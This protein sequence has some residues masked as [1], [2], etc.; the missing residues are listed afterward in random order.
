MR[1]ARLA[2]A[3]DPDASGQT[4]IIGADGAEDLSLF[5][6]ERTLIVESLAH[7]HHALAQRGFRVATA[8][9]GAFDTV[10]VTLPRARDAARA[11]IALGA[12]HL[13]PEGAMW[14]DGRKTDGVESIIKEIRSLAGIS[15]VHSKA[16]GKIARVSDPTAIT[17]DWLQDS[18]SPAPGFITRA[19]MF[20]ATEPD[21]GSQLLA[22]ALP[23]RMPT[24]VVDL[25][26]GW[27]WLSAQILARPGVQMLHLV[28]ADHAALEAARMNIKDVRAQFHWADA[29]SFRLPDPVN[30]VVMNPPFHS[31]RDADPGLGAAFIRA[32]AG[33]LTGAGRLWMV[34][35]RHLP[36]EADLSSYFG[37]V[38]EIGGDNRF[39]LLMA[40]GA[41]SRKPR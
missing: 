35:N 6:P 31:G 27:G 34:A 33:L 8:P 17:S 25:G 18:L 21:P 15:E 40:T 2:L 37:E 29:R 5:D 32:A 19:G 24:R 11:R 4:L 16:H 23:E 12:A 14:L 39:K 38:T 26:A 30:A 9:E 20:S 10:L 28:E 22:T 1:F 7:N 41:R 13:A 36:Y 3:F